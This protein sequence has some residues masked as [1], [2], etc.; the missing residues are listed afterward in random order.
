MNYRRIVIALLFNV[1]VFLLSGE[2]LLRAFDPWGA[3][4][5]FNDLALLFGATHDAPPRTFAMQP[6][7]YHFSNWT[8]TIA[9]DS[10]RAVP[11]SRPGACR[12]AFLGDSVTFGYGVDDE[13][14]WI[15]LLARELPD[16]AM[17]NTGMT[18]YNLDD[19][20]ATYRQLSADA[21]VY[22]LIDNDADP[23]KQW[24][25]YSPA[26]STSALLDY[27]TVWQWQ[28]GDPSIPDFPAVFFATL[29]KLMSDR[30]VTVVGFQDDDLARQSADRYPALEL[31]PHWTHANSRADSHA[32]AE[33]NA[34]IAAAMFPIVKDVVAHACNPIIQGD[35]HV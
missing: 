14:T 22:L 27:A 7:I 13:Q 1:L 20:V 15:D 21:Y 8:A 29:G 16:A 35:Y 30:R 5:Y 19:V 2:A 9:A 32:N 25:R 3:R 6:G 10:Y 26:D 18:G 17:I 34:E 24:W 31:I 28:H 11:D 33:G 4:R 23:P 12:I